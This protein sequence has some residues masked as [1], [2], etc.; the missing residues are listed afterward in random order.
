MIIYF[1]KSIYQWKDKPD[2][3]TCIRDDGSVTWMHLHR[4]FVEHG[5]AHYIVETTLENLEHTFF[6]LL[7][8]GSDISDFSKPKAE[9]P[10]EIP[11][12]A[13]TIEPII[14]LLQADLSSEKG[15]IFEDHS[16]SL[17]VD[18]TEKQWEL[19]RQELYDFLE[20]W[21]ELKPGEAMMLRLER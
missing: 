10:F 16:A 18:V 21:R 15:L 1:K 3:L 14:A 17:P 9:R 20:W 5:I 7:A 6:G 12:G 4:G 2:T 13:K 19:M 8:K 11:E